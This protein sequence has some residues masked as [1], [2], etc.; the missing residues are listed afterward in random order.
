MT[1]NQA[2]HYEAIGHCV[3]LKE[4]I[5]SRIEFL[6]YRLSIIHELGIAPSYF[7][8]NKPQISIHE[9]IIDHVEK[10]ANETK[11]IYSDIYRSAVEYNK[12]AELAGYEA[13]TILYDQKDKPLLENE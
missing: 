5:K 11:D 2:P 12:W 13:I 10:L 9:I 1:L 4:K 7:F 8:G 3:F 6:E